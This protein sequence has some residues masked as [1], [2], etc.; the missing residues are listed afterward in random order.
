MNPHE[1]HAHRALLNGL[2]MYYEVHGEG[3]PL[4]ML[5]GG[6]STIQ[7][8]FGRLLPLLARHRQ[9]ISIELQAH[10]HTPDRDTPESFAQDAADARALLQHLGI[11]KADVLGFSNGGQTALQL[12]ISH[13]AVVNRLVV[14]SA[15]YKH[16]GAP[17]GFFEGFPDVTLDAMPGVYQQA[18]LAIPGNTQAGLQRMF[19]QD[20]N[21]MMRFEDWTDEDIAGIGAP[22][23]IIGGDRDVVTPGHLAGMSARMKSARLMILPGTH[24]SFIGEA[25]SETPDMQTVRFVAKEIECFLDEM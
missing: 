22:C 8:S 3:R 18:Y 1:S 14:I 6:G 24:G 23:F 10:G 15:F 25:M 12:A 5:H 20:R 21:R 11:E 16:E 7:T 4:L 9:V 17:S 13:P 2:D 19:E